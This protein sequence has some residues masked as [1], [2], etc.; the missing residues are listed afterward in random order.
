MASKDSSA[1]S[2]P[3]S[4]AEDYIVIKKP[5]PLTARVLRDLEAKISSQEEDLK[6]LD[7]V[8]KADGGKSRSGPEQQRKDLMSSLAENLKQYGME[9]FWIVFP[10]F[11]L[12]DT[13][14]HSSLTKRVCT[15]AT[16]EVH[17][18]S[19]ILAQQ[20]DMASVRRHLQGMAGGSDNRCMIERLHRK[21]IENRADLDFR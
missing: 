17:L 11:V 18:P 4:S 19:S 9:P 13:Q 15:A 12:I 20:W 1:G 6:E 14:T 2:P 8:C 10:S 5:D 7:E 3:S 21:L 16:I